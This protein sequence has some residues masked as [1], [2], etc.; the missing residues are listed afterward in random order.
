MICFYCHKN[1]QDDGVQ[2]TDCYKMFFYRDKNRYGR[3]IEHWGICFECQSNR[4]I[5]DL[6]REKM[7]SVSE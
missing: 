2:I 1:K 6:S 3:P 7:K 5:D 4:S